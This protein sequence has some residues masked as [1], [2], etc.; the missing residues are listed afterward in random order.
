MPWTRETPWRQGSIV[1]L[2]A[3]ISLGLIGEHHSS[4]KLAIV[5]S[6]DCDLANEIEEE[7][8]V[9][10]VVGTQIE[11]CLPDKTHAKNVRILHLEID[12][13][14]G[15]KAVELVARNRVAI[16]KSRMA[17]FGPDREYLLGKAELGTLRSWLA[18]RYKRASIPDGLQSLIKDIF[19]DVAKKKERP[20]ALRGIWVDFDPDLDRLLPGEHY[21][22]WI[23]VV[24][25][26]AEAGSKAVAEDAVRQIKDKF[27]RK[28]HKGGVW[29]GL[30]LR[31]CVARSDTE[32]TYYDT[33]R[34]KL[35]RLEYLSLR[36]GASDELG[37][38]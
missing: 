29:T 9:E 23:V 10:I 12:T 21:E 25:S 16:P 38:E 4:E 7:P 11:D 34:Y 20:H 8:D 6:H 14:T 2:G 15:K 36:T 3:A 30:D 22:L 26:T 37:N 5:I 13:A 35:F 31:E 28:Y 24:Y 27:E 18:A 17:S 32:F 19:Q 1:P 33:Y